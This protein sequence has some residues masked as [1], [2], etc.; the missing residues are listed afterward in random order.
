MEKN[1]QDKLKMVEAREQSVEKEKLQ[2]QVSCDLRQILIF[3]FLI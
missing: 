2:L 3:N 1:Y